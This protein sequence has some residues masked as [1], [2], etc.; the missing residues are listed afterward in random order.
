MI[1]KIQ[2]PR[3][4][5]MDSINPLFSDY[6][7]VR[8][9]LGGSLIYQTQNTGQLETTCIQCTDA[10]ARLVKSVVAT[11]MKNDSPDS[12]L[13]KITRPGD[14]RMDYNS[15]VIYNPNWSW[16]PGSGVKSID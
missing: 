2:Y 8:D 12:F 15:A 3:P 16:L 11:F 9:N 7:K 1:G 4:V 13:R 14:G 6:L 5:L 10:L